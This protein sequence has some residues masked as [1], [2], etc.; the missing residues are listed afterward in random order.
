MTKD[1]NTIRFQPRSAIPTHKK[2]MYDRIAATLCLKKEEIHRIR[3]TSSADRLDYFDD[4]STPTTNLT[5]TQI[6]F[7]RVIST[8]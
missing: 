7:N 4:T 2:I 8:P 3:L 6:Y 1:T 5:T